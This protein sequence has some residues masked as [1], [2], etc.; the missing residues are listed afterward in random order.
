MFR[1]YVSVKWIGG[2]SL[3]FRSLRAFE[4]EV[5]ADAYA[6]LVRQ[7]CNGPVDSIKVWVE[8]VTE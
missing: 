6:M 2:E 4:T 7:T 3:S 8:P 5:A 1:V